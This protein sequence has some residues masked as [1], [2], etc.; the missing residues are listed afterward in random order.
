MIWNIQFAHTFAP[1]CVVTA[2]KLTWL[3]LLFSCATA[4]N[5]LKSILSAINVTHNKLREACKTTQFS[6]ETIAHCRHRICDCCNRL[7]QK[8]TKATEGNGWL[9]FTRRGNACH[10]G[11]KDNTAANQ[12]LAFPEIINTYLRGSEMLIGSLVIP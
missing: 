9:L 11:A 8:N 10:A 6:Q 7:S 2:I 5:V 3:L 12:H 4:S 1:D